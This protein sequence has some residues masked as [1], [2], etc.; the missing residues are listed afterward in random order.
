MTRLLN[1]TQEKTTKYRKVC[2]PTDLEI[3]EDVVIERS[4]PED[5]EFPLRSAFIDKNITGDSY[6]TYIKTESVLRKEIV[7]KLI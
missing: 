2:H 7:I 6:S 1:K 4:L 5:T 3:E